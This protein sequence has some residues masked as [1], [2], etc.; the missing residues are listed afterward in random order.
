M[1]VTAL[2]IV[3]GVFFM[4]IPTFASPPTNVD[5]TPVDENPVLPVGEDG[6]WDDLSVRFPKVVFHGDQYHMFYTS[7]QSIDQ[8]QAIG[9]A[10]SGDG[11]NWERVGDGPVFEASEGDG[12][13]SFSVSSSVVIVEE[14]GTWVMY[15]NGTDTPG[16]PPFGEGIGRATASS[17]SGPWERLDEPVLEAGSLRRWD[18]AFIFPD[19]VLQTDE[20]GYMMYFSGNGTG[21][22]RVGLALSED[23][24][25]WTK[26]D[27]PETTDTAYD[28]SDPILPSG[29]VGAWDFTVAWGVGVVKTEYGYEMLYTG[30]AS[31]DG[32]FKSSLGYAYSEDGIHFTPYE[33]NPVVELEGSQTTLFVSLLVRDEQY[34]A[35]YGAAQ[36]TFTEPNLAT[37]TIDH[38][39]NR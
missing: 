31:G 25:N 34:M 33:D 20:G 8:P 16:S 37:G 1:K 17:P 29:D 30:G 15:Y 4:A 5:F 12:W 10:V 27:D 39:Q 32:G 18:G 9:Y 19:A 24:I 26:Y 13:D 23:G 21:K 28:E 11:I 3:L 35:Y 36:G 6:S 38:V 14:D 7:F 2:L 22:G